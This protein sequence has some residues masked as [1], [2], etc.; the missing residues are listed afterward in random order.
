MHPQDIDFSCECIQQKIG[1]EMFRQIRCHRVLATLCLSS[2]VALT[3]PA[4]ARIQCDGPY[5]IIQGSKV[6]TPYCED[7]YLAHVARSYGSGVTPEAIRHNPNLKESVCR[8]MGADIRV[9]DICSG[10]RDEDRR[11]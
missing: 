8:F 11:P 2:V 3:N 10:L 5:Q 1:I 7:S 9:K 6:A 4:A